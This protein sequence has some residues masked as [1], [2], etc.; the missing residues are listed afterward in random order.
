[1]KSLIAFIVTII[2]L[3]GVVFLSDYVPNTAFVALFISVFL[4]GI[5]VTV[6]FINA[7]K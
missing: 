2:A 4:L 6:K 1:M 5:A 3:G 7:G